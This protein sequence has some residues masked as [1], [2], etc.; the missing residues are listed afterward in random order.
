MPIRIRPL[1]CRL[2]P[3]L[4]TA[5]GIGD[6]WDDSCPAV[7]ERRDA[8]LEASIEG[9]ARAEALQWHY[10]LYSE[11]VLEESCGENRSDL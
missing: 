2:H 3:R 6:Q 8:H 7:H 9:T 11:I 10:M 5:S 1:I 4:Y